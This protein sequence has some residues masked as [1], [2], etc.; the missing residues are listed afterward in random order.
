[1][2]NFLKYRFVAISFSVA[3]L[4][5]FVGLYVTKGGLMY[6]VEF[7]GGT[8]ALF[9][10]EK[11]VNSKKLLQDVKEKW[12]GAVAREFSDTQV[13]VRVQQHKG[14]ARGLADRIREQIQTTNPDNPVT[15]ESS[16]VVGP[17]VGAELRWRSL[18][19]I[20]L[21]LL[22]MMLYIVIRFWSI[23]YAVGAAVALLHDALMILGF[24]LLFGREISI[25]VIGALLAVIGY[26]INDSI[27][28]FSRIRENFKKMSSASAS[29]VVN[30]SLNQ[31]FKRTLLT[32]FS[33]LLAVGSMFLLGGEVL[34]D[35]SLVL[36]MG[37]FFGTYSSIYIASP[38]MMLFHKKEK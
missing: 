19:T 27:V 10:F 17:G 8:Q 2:I 14:D 34:R 23:G 33:T 1:M 22:L 20:A 4:A 26:S 3:L 32:S 15:I 37:I 28:I 18:M 5:L 25:N 38:V 16:E 29:E 6:S 36:L 24:M 9:K 21:A 35:F 31:T 30:T 7:T 13:L 11:P 12:S